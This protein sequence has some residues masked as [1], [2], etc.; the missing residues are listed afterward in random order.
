[1]KN[2]KTTL[3]GVATLLAVASKIATAG[4]LDFNADVPAILAAVGLIA[5]KDCDV[6][7]GTT[8]Q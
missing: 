7:G 1:M 3:A 8:R 6:T 5:A 2:W 4:H